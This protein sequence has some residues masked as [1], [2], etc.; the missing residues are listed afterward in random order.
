MNK[1]IALSVVIVIL[2]AAGGGYALWQQNAGNNVQESAQQ[3]R[4]NKN[5]QADTP[6]Q[7]PDENRQETQQDSNSSNNQDDQSIKNTDGSSDADQTEQP[8][9]TI[10]LNNFGQQDD[11]TVYANATINGVTDGTCEFRFNRNGASVVETTAIERA[12]TGYYA[13]GVRVGQNAFT[14]KG[15]WTVRVHI[16]DTDPRVSSGERTTRIE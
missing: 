1:R 12:P 6:A 2:L 3:T 7:T 13:C 4:D 9:G 16:Q 10:T 11:G 14:P 15:R 5:K 8:D